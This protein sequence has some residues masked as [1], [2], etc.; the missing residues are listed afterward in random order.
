MESWQ[1]AVS[2]VAALRG[3]AMAT[4]LP[5][6]RDKFAD[7]VHGG[8]FEQL[9][10]AT[11]APV[12]GGRKRLMVQC[13]QLYVLSHAALLGDAT[14]Q[15][16]AERGYAFLRRCY[17]D[18]ENGGWFFRTDE[19]GEA[20]DRSKDLYGHAFLL[21]ALAYLHRA[22]AAPDALALAAATYDEV[23]EKMAAP[24]GGFWDRA[25]EAWEPDRSIRRQNPH[26]HLL[27]ALLA[28]HEAS[29]QPR[30]LAEADKLVTLFLHRFL[31]P[32]TG[33][34]GEYF[35]AD[36]APD[37]V[38]GAIV[39]PGHHF[40]WVWL[41]H[42]YRAAGGAVPVAEASARLFAVADA[43]GYDPEHAGIHDQIDR[44]GAP[45]LTSR[46]IWPVT[47]A[48]KAH[49][50]RIEAGEDV[51]AGQP[52]RLIAHLFADFLR[53]E[54]HGWIETMSRE[55]TPKQTTLPGSTPYHLFLAAA[56]AARVL[57]D[58]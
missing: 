17:R 22:F 33:T 26:M 21:F 47:E 52:D 15:T 7:P 13:R 27:E 39:E 9:D 2:H 16:A 36:W 25:D 24:G 53:P 55:G 32:A 46:R 1:I 3:F 35:T 58:G 28:L 5:L 4:L 29:G 41:L 6:C 38:M 48:I 18:Q 34:L 37:P 11:H 10:P 31:D 54:R 44:A 14:G 51:P 12:P 19:A 30:W 8:F 50:A 23:A 42:R 45:L 57:G 49:T 40:E 43:H 56:E 20:A